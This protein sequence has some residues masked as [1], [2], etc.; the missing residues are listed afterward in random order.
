[1]AKRISKKSL[2]K[3]QAEDGAR[4][5]IKTRAPKSGHDTKPEPAMPDMTAIMA[6]SNQ[7]VIDA[8]KSIPTPIA[9]TEVVIDP[10]PL[11]KSIHVKNISRNGQNRIE[12][13]DFDVVYEE[14]VL[15]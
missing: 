12:S 3:L 1:M 11:V 13:A 6:D 2:D 15:N 8:I 9:Q 4:V 14:R 7:K 5:L 10:R